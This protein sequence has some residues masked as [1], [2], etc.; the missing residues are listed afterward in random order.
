[1]LLRKND[2]FFMHGTGHVLEDRYGMVGCTTQYII[3]AKTP[4][5]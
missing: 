4:L 5:K 2:E 3:M 1:M